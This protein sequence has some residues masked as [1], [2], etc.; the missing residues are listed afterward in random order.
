MRGFITRT[1]F[2]TSMQDEFQIMCYLAPYCAS[3]PHWLMPVILKNDAKLKQI[4]VG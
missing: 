3:N 4:S 2:G 1:G